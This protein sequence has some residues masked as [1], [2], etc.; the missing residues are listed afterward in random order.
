MFGNK[1]AK[2]EKLAQKG[3]AEK[4]KGLVNDKKEDVRLAA[5]D[6]LGRCSD[7]VAFNTLTTLINSPDAQTRIHVVKAM[8]ETKQPK[9]RAFLEHR[10][11]LEKDP[12]VLAVI[13]DVCKGT[14][15]MLEG[16]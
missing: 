15:S 12:K 11:E 14:K 6:A 8:A 3:N 4:L 5:I 2:I 7:E 10:K 16:K 9:V 13:N 1:L